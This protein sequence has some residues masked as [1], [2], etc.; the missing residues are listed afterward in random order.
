[1]NRRRERDRED[2][3]DGEVEAK[4]NV[5]VGLPIVEASKPK[6]PG[7]AS[8]KAKK[9]QKWIYRPEFT[10]STNAREESKQNMVNFD[11]AM[12]SLKSIVSDK[13][14]PF[15]EVQQD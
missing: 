1:M 6:V 12:K 4:I 8:V 3:K 11:E 5:G 14:D 7:Q 10:I 13:N 2:A 9:H 15:R